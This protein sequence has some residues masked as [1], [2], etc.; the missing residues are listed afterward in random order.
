MKN[1]DVV[2]IGGGPAGLNCAKHL[3]NKSALILEKEKQLG[4]KVCAAGL[5]KKAINYLNLPEYIYDV[6]FKKAIFHTRLITSQTQSNEA[7]VATIDRIKLAKW[8]A[9]K[10]GSAELRINSEVTGITKDYVII[11]NK[12]KI[13][14]KYLVG[15]D[16]PNSLVRKFL[17]IKTSKIGI[18]IHYLIKTDKYK[19]IEG[20]L[21]SALF[22]S[23][24]AWIFP[25]K[26]Y[27]SIGCFANP[28]VLSADKL[29]KNFQIWLKKNKI[30][31]SK[32][33]FESC[34]IN[35]D[36]NGYKFG[37]V[38]LTGDAA[39]LASPLTGEGIY[40]ALISGEEVAKCIMSPKYNSEAMEKLI[41]HH[42][43]HEMVSNILIKSWHLREIFF[44]LSAL[45]LRS[46]RL[47]KFGLKHFG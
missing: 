10:I 13:F 41:R 18:G 4:K 31:Y 11:N 3:S 5:T 46:K 7:F 26:E 20:Y 17:G 15:A 8:Q 6:K 34:P 35:F 24:Y 28:K 19:Q 1:Y 2:I 32:G 37:N 22:N 36:Y 30:D 16:G 44:F 27:V 42:W 33:L 25:H 39:G 29:K 14:Y 38:F 23:G 21:D 40:Q 43:H 47:A 12:E 9:G 45:A